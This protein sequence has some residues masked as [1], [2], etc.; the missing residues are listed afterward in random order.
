MHTSFSDSAILG[1]FNDDC[2]SIGRQIDA[3]AE[4]LRAA[5]QRISRLEADLEEC[6]EYFKDRCDVVDGDCGEQEPNSEMKLY[7]MIHETLHGPGNF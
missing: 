3:K 6:A 5:Y 4:E 7:S 1:K 2:E